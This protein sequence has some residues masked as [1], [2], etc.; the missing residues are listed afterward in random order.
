MPRRPRCAGAGATRHYGAGTDGQT[1]QHRGLEKA[2]HLGES[3]CGGDGLLTKEGDVEQVQ[4]IDGEN[5]HEPDCPGAGHNHD[6]AHN[7]VG[8]EAC[9][10]GILQVVHLYVLELG[11]IRSGQDVGCM[12]HLLGVIRR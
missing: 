1:D 3:N 12:A 11:T 6:V 9:I 7:I 8:N 4:Q 2:N 10:A 5:R